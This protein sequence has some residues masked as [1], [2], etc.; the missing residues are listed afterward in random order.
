MAGARPIISDPG[1]SVA[2]P[3]V[4]RRPRLL[5][6]LSGI[7]RRRHGDRAPRRRRSALQRD[8]SRRGRLPADVLWAWLHFHDTAGPRAL[9]LRLSLVLPGHVRYLYSPPHRAHLHL[10]RTDTD[11]ILCLNGTRTKY[12]NGT[13][14]L[15]RKVMVKV[16]RESSPVKDHRRATQPDNRDG[17][18]HNNIEIVSVCNMRYRPISN[19]QAISTA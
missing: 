18:I 15:C 5:P 3:A 13:V 16:T 4:A 19:R 10:N 8:L 14:L 2:T 17:S 9:Q 1:R 12:I 11:P 7:L 6:E